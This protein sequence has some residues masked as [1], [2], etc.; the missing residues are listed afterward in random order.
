MGAQ[1]KEVRA[2]WR[3][4]PRVERVARAILGLLVL[5]YGGVLGFDRI[6]K[7]PA[8]LDAAESTLIRHDSAIVSIQR[9]VGEQTR[10]QDYLICLSEA[11]AG[12]GSKT[13]I[14]C[15]NDRIRAERQ[16]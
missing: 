15:A 3:E 14:Q 5:L 16:P 12:I 2:W 9:V 13:P 11:A 1:V 6:Y 4:L 8:R 10:T 7:G